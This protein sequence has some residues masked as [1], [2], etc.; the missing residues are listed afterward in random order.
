MEQ[1]DFSGWLSGDSLK[2]RGEGQPLAALSRA[3][4]RWSLL[5]IRLSL[6]SGRGKRETWQTPKDSLLILDEPESAL[7]STAEEH[8]VSGLEL[9]A[10]EMGLQIV[11]ATH[12]PALLDASSANILRVHRE[13]DTHRRGPTQV[14]QLSAPTLDVIRALGMTPSDLLR[15]YRAFMLVEG[16]H[17]EIVLRALIGTE[18]DAMKVRLLPLHG[19]R[20]FPHTVDSQW[21]FDFTDALIIAIVDNGEP[22]LIQQTWEA[23][24]LT[25]LTEGVE[26]AGEVVRTMLP[27]SQSAENIFLGGFMTRALERGQGSRVLP[28]AFTKADIVEYLP[29]EAFTLRG[30]WD[31][32][33]VEHQA[34][35]TKQNFKEWLF[36]QHKVSFNDAQIEAAAASLD[37]LPQDFQ[38]LLDM[39]TANLAERESPEGRPY[40]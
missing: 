5:A 8:M 22:E 3:E 23:G 40:D 34:S 24:Q 10:H 29:V 39:C 20:R 36:K 11:V 26:A 13:P 6:A 15:R 28:H 33:H 19:A 14:S 1:G 21:L 31:Q 38:A 17:D 9:L 18:L 4:R 2:W 35:G 12:S 27:K 32:L 16:R 37:A 7:H 25:D 30:T